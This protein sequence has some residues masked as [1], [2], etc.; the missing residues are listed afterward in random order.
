MNY[1]EGTTYEE[2]CHIAEAEVE[3][4]RATDMGQLLLELAKLRE[5]LAE[6]KEA[7]MWSDLRDRIAAALGEK[8]GPPERVVSQREHGSDSEW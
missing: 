3:Q 6:A 5:L 8:M 1:P 2:R 4:Y 7:V